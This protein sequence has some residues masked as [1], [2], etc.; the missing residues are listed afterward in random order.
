MW[1]LLFLEFCGIFFFHLDFF[2][3]DCFCFGFYY[4]I[5]ILLLMFIHLLGNPNRCRRNYNQ[6][7]KSRDLIVCIFFLLRPLIC[8]STN[9]IRLSISISIQLIPATSFFY[10]NNFLCVIKTETIVHFYESV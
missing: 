10:Y 8:S 2:P 7:K 1:F 9:K 4:L 3:F 6:K 5:F